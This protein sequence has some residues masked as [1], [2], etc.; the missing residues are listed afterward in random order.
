VSKSCLDC[1]LADLE[2]AV[3]DAKSAIATIL[4]FTPDAKNGF[5]AT[6][7]HESFKILVKM[8]AFLHLKVISMEI[9]QERSCLFFF[10]H[11]NVEVRNFVEIQG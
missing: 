1:I 7:Y 4:S 9:C 10:I 11:K 5:Y 8:F 2:K 3:R 6:I